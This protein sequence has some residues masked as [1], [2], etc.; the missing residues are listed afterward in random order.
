MHN[1]SLYTAKGI[2]INRGIGNPHNLI[3]GYNV[4]GMSVKLSLDELLKLE[5]VI[6]KRKEDDNKI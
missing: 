2:S 3:K 5:E 4:K 1:E 6:I